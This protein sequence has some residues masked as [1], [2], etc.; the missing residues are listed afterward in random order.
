MKKKIW[1]YFVVLGVIAGMLLPVAGCGKE[2]QAG[3]VSTADQGN[4]GGPVGNGQTDVKFGL[5]LPTEGLGDKN[6]CDMGYEGLL[7]A[8]KDFGIEFTYAEPKSVSDYEAAFR[9]YAESGEYELILGLGSGQS[10]AMTAVASEFPD[11]KFGIVDSQVD[12]SNVSCYSTKWPEQTFLC[13]V[14]A[15]LGTLD[16]RFE[17]ANEENV[18]GAILGADYPS[19]RSGVVGFEA[20]VRYV[21]PDCEVLSA[22]VGDFNDPAKGKEVSLSMYKRGA[23]FIQQI[24]GATG[25]GLFSAAKEADRYAIGVG[26]SQSYI[27]PDYIIATSVGNVHLMIYNEIKTTLDGTWE[28]GVHNWGIKE[29]AV[30][31][32]NEDSNITIPEDVLAVIEEIKG[33]VSSGELI[34]PSTEEELDEW[35]TQHQY[36]K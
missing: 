32:S 21:N 11:Q 23:D 20:G 12:M 36:S 17:K 3:D 31:F 24:A 2:G 1:R 15:G 7:M 27:E 16:D 18:V 35:L 26:K 34:P 5:I 4:S 13:G 33:K 6:F 19:L 9:M 30:G 10:D 14:L 22:V 8:Q 25:L 29:D 28:P